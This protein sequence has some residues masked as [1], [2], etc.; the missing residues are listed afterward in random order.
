MVVVAGIDGV[1][2][3]DCTV[4]TGGGDGGCE[5]RIGGSI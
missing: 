2:G 1:G 3:A 5:V 4:S